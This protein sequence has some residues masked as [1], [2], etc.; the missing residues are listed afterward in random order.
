MCV[1]EC[2]AY[3]PIFFV[4]FLFYSSDEDLDSAGNSVY[5]DS[6][7]SFDEGIYS[8]PIH[9]YVNLSGFGNGSILGEL[10]T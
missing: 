10:N 9:D 7:S 8:Q 2:N 1:C 4:F 3:G 6:Y 5:G